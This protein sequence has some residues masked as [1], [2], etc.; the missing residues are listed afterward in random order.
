MFYIFLSICCCVTVSVLLKLAKRYEINVAHAVVWNYLVAAGLAGAIYK[1]T[2]GVVMKNGSL[3][4]L[5]ILLGILLPLLFVFL[6][7]SVRYTGIVRTELAQRLSL[8]IPLLV[9]FS[10]FGEALSVVKLIGAA[11]GFV[12]ILFTVS[13]SKAKVP[14]SIVKEWTWLY[15][16]IV[17]F[18]MGVIDVLF[19]QLAVYQTIP[20]TTSLFVVLSLAFLFSV[21]TF[22]IA[23]AFKKTRFNMVNFFCG[24][25]LGLF[26]FGNILFYLKAHRAISSNP[27][28]VF[29]AMNIGVIVAGT[30]VGVALFRERLTLI[31]KIGIVLALAAIL[32]ISFSGKIL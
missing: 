22:L 23:F 13:R 1:P 7:R 14:V 29:S 28:I 17:F 8:F 12:A 16:L 27:S 18:G 9:S 20:Y 15:P 26:N 5:Y 32:L 3:W 2:V 25:L 19:R 24:L 4:G 11:L 31:N 10:L 6:G 21:S 30:F